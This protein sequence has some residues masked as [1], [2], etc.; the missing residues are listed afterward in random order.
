MI[1]RCIDAVFQ[2]DVLVKGRGSS[3]CLV[4]AAIEP[5]EAHPRPAAARI[6]HDRQPRADALHPHLAAFSVVAA[7]VGEGDRI[8]L[9]RD[10][11]LKS[12]L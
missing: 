12:P 10:L 8:V 9:R 7:V 1:V 11:R 2:T 4:R 5:G 3:V 6:V